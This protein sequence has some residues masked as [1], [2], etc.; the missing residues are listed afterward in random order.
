MGSIDIRRLSLDQLRV[1]RDVLTEHLEA[2]DGSELLDRK[3]RAASAALEA[4]VGANVGPED[5]LYSLLQQAVGDREAA[6]KAGDVAVEETAD[7]INTILELVVGHQLA[8]AGTA[9][10]QTTDVYSDPPE[11]RRPLV[12]D[13]IEN[14][15]GIE[16]EDDLFADPDTESE[17]LT[18]DDEDEVAMPAD[19][20]W[21]ALDEAAAAAEEGAQRGS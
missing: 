15:G 21:A 14:V 13:V 8:A 6:W 7:R 2:R 4:F 16:D 20:V 17:T 18:G 12:R 11:L 5:D 19:D 3:V 1:F 9:P 10:A